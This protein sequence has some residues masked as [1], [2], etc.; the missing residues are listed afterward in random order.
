[1][2]PLWLIPAL[3]VGALLGCL[4]TALCV[5]AARGDDRDLP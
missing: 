2:S 5:A 3:F 4:V 1:M